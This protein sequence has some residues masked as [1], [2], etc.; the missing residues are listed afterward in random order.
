MSPGA[1]THTQNTCPHPGF[2]EP[3][4]TQIS[5]FRC[6][7]LRPL[8]ENTLLDPESPFLS[9]AAGGHHR[10]AAGA[11]QLGAG[12]A[13]STQAL[14]VRSRGCRLAAAA[15]QV[16]PCFKHVLGRL[17]N[18]TS[19]KRKNC[20]S[21]VWGACILTSPCTGYGVWASHLAPWCLGFPILKV[22]VTM[23]IMLNNK[24]S[25]LFRAWLMTGAEL[26]SCSRVCGFYS[27]CVG[28]ERSTLR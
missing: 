28:P 2:S 12:E 5:S 18:D 19:F 26:W 3:P 14:R 4:G 13:E 1:L 9:P 15:G 6:G 21:S 25:T 27:R 24:Q 17:C 7:V 11:K 16:V 8:L 20:W 10:L 22:V 23:T